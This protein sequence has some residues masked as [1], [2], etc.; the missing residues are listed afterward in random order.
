MTDFE[1]TKQLLIEGQPEHMRILF[2]GTLDQLL[3][4]YNNE[5]KRV[6]IDLYYAVPGQTND[7][8][9]WPDELTTA[10]EQA[11]KIIT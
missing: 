2:A 3:I 1:K 10:M 8:D 11:F 4:Q 7:K 5:C 9:W 6:L